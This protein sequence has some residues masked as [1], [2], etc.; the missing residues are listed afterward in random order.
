MIL[1]Q[2]QQIQEVLE[3]SGELFMRSAE[4]AELVEC[5]VENYSVESYVD[6]ETLN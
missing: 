5:P 6:M 2:A 4:F 1:L 3:Y